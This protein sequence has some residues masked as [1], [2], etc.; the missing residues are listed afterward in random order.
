[1]HRAAL[2]LQYGLPNRLHK[3]G[4]WFGYDCR[5]GGQKTALRCDGI[6]SSATKSQNNAGELAHT[7]AQLA[8]ACIKELELL[9]SS[10]DNEQIATYKL[11]LPS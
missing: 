11:D 1:M 9:F 8:S 6:H 5:E 4:P 3:S 2:T 7:D 10:A